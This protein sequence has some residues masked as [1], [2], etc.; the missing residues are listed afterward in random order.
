[1]I[2]FG[3]FD[4]LKAPW[5]FYANGA[6]FSVSSFAYDLISSLI[7]VYILRGSLLC[8]SPRWKGQPLDR[9]SRIGKA[10]LY[11]IIAS[12]LIPFPWQWPFFQETPRSA[13]PLFPRNV[14]QCLACGR[15]LVTTYHNVILSLGFNLQLPVGYIYLYFIC[16][17]V[18]ILSLLL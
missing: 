4:L 18:C 2:K 1:M 8:S 10:T 15:Y 14:T 5:G 11:P 9:F 6:V 3:E 17:C 7:C 12:I 13:L 16:V